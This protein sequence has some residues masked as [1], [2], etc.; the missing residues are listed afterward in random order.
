MLK[1]Y[2]KFIAYKLGLL[3]P[4]HYVPVCAKVDLGSK[5]GKENQNLEI[6]IESYQ[7][8]GINLIFKNK[9]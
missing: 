4:H 5:D 3:H 8:D 6:K 1:D 2:R 7:E 9:K